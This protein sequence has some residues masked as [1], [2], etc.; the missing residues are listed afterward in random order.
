MS[1]V[2]DGAMGALQDWDSFLSVLRMEWAICFLSCGG[3]PCTN[4]SEASPM[5]IVD[6]MK[7]GPCTVLDH[8][9][10]YRPNLVRVCAVPS[11][12][13]PSLFSGD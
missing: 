2:A 7:S 1:S 10:A 4:R 13:R 9:G 3:T 6:M 11:S 12:L 5:A 8:S